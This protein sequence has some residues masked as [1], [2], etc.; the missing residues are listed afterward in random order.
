K[1]IPC[2][3]PPQID[4]G[5][6]KSSSSA[7]ERRET[8][9]MNRGCMH[10]APKGF[11]I[12]EENGITCYMGKWSPSPQC[13]DASCVNSSQVESDIIQNQESRYQS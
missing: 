6:V 2:F 1:K 8:H 10:T 4:R 11:R 12:S 3:Q 9:D 5:T 7:E 13:I